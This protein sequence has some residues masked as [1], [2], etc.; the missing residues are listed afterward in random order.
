MSFFA[1]AY[2]RQID[3]LTHIS[4]FWRTYES[5]DTFFSVPIIYSLC[6][7]CSFLLYLSYKGMDK[8]I[9]LNQSVSIDLPTLLD[10]RLLVQANSGGGKSWL[11]RRLLEQSQ[12]K[13]QQIVIDLEGEFA[14]L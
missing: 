4:P 13:V 10:T 12:G 9:F 7:S 6:I 3:V 8:H 1:D 14:T 11:L 2:P 5:N